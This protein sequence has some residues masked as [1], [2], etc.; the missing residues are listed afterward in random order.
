VIRSDVVRKELA[1]P[2]A[3]PSVGGASDEGIYAPEWTQRTYEECLR[4]A[5]RL[6]LDGQRVIVDAT[7]ARDAWR[8]TFLQAARAWGV[9]VVL[10]VCRAD[11]AVVRERLARRRGDVSDADWSVYQLAAARWEAASAAVQPF[12]HEITTDAGDAQVRSTAL[13]ALQEHGIG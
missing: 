7:F 12:L 4:R 2:D 8:V 6:L 1:G 9:P 3:P 11:P 5:E 10:L 13:A